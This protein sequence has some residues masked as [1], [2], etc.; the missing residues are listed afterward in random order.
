MSNR[1][2]AIASLVFLML[3]WGSTFVVTKAAV[4]ETPPML[5][6]F[7]RFVVAAVVLLPLAVLRGGFK[8][9]PRPLP[10]GTM[11]LMGLT[12]FVVYYAG[13]NYAIAYA[14]ASQG[15]LIQALIPAVIALAAVLFLHERPS[16]KRWI[17]IAL[18]IAGVALVV[19]ASG[20]DDEARHPV[21]GAVLMFG[22]VVTWAI[23]TV[24]AKRVA[25][26]DQIVVTGYTLTLGT[27]LMIPPVLLEMR[28]EP[29]PEISAST[30]MAIV[31]L[32]V[33][34]SAASFFIYNRAL[35]DLDASEVAVYINL[36][37]IVGVATAVMFFGESLHPL[38]LFGG[39]IALVGMWLSS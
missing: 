35:R 27:L 20:S 37:P 28:H 32:G 4:A 38:Q 12:G 16:R 36:I 24:L 15:A 39:V 22:T 3:V 19:S 18:S 9:L 6:A 34:A 33:V 2:V 10:L 1:A 29:W 7:L 13:F 8:R 5:A 11:L 25:H 21:L 30:W 31:Y 17:G 14:S 26:A 23:Y